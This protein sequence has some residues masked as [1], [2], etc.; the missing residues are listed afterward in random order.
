M[1]KENKQNKQNEI[2]NGL[3]KFLDNQNQNSKK[4]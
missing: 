2:I 4:G 1:D 3:I